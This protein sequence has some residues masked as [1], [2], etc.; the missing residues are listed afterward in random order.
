M[1]RF[2]ENSGNSFDCP[3]I[4]TSR[5]KTNLNQLVEVKL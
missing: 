3:F 4:M 5:T 1:M 2:K